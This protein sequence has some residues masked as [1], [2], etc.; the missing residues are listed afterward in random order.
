[1][2]AI[3]YA[4]KVLHGVK[5]RTPKQCEIADRRIKSPYGLDPKHQPY[6][7]PENSRH[8]QRALTMKAKIMRRAEREA[9]KKKKF[10][11]LNPALR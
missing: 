11:Y 1:M 3:V 8:R 9:Y 10:C 5:Q 6:K 7:S 2:F 4:Q